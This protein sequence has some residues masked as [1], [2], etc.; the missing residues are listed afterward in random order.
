MEIHPL[1]PSPF[2]HIY[3]VHG[4][5]QPVKIT[6]VQL[7]LNYPVLFKLTFRKRLRNRC[8]HFPLILQNLCIIRLQKN[9]YAPFYDL[10]SLQLPPPQYFHAP[11]NAFCFEP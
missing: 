5:H 7:V 11:H 2:L 6:L 1:L 3:I 10:P 8:R 4:L 9:P